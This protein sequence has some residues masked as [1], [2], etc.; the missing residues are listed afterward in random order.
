MLSHYNVD[1]EMIDDVICIRQNI[2]NSGFAYLLKTLHTDGYVDSGKSW[3]TMHD[4]GLNERECQIAV[5]EVINLLSKTISRK[6]DMI[7]EMER[8]YN[9][10]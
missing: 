10:R 2:V 1:M 4:M 9:D 6:D 3:A 5:N 8:C 7:D